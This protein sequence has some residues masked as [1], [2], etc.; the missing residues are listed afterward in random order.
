MACIDPAHIRWVEQGARAYVRQ[1]KDA[2]SR[3]R[4]P[5]FVTDDNKAS[6]CVPLALQI[7]C[8][9]EF[10]LDDHFACAVWNFCTKYSYNPFQ[11]YVL[12]SSNWPSNT[13]MSVNMVF[14]IKI[15]DPKQWVPSTISS[16]D[17]VIALE[18]DPSEWTIWMSL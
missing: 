14:E 11:Q 18:L 10:A 17:L 6:V 9:G 13:P 2:Q 16:E 5:V 15:T 8:V 12:Y 4:E 7:G 3:S 1:L